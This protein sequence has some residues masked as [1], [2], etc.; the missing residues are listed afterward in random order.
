MKLNVNRLVPNFIWAQRQKNIHAFVSNC[1]HT[2][3]IEYY[4][5]LGTY[6][7]KDF[8]HNLSSAKNKVFQYFNKQLI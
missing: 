2:Y 6:L 4:T 5:S 3:K 1:G 7:G 8:S